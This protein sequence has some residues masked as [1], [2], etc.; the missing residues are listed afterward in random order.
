MESMMSTFWATIRA[1][2]LKRKRLKSVGG[3][4]KSKKPWDVVKL[5]LFSLRE[6]VYKGM[7][8][9]S[10]FFHPNFLGV[11]KKTKIDQGPHN[12]EGG[13]WVSLSWIL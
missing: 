5:Q 12:Q 8:A 7:L 1:A 11:D 3:P 6:L 13:Q 10:S 9:L 2:W 4:L